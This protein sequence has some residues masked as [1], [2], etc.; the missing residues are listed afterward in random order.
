[1]FGSGP[2]GDGGTRQTRGRGGQGAPS[3]DGRRAAQ[4]G[5]GARQAGESAAAGGL[6]PGRPRDARAPGEP[7]PRAGAPGG[8]GTHRSAS[9][10]PPL[11]SRYLSTSENSSLAKF[12]E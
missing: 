1:M 3:G 6:L 9:G 2:G 5:A 12:A 10:R 4:G 8:G 7:A 11:P